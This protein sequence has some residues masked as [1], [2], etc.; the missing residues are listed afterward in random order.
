MVL[1]AAKRSRVAAESDSIVH[2]MTKI[3][4]KK[5][6]PVTTG[7]FKSPLKLS[8]HV[9]ALIDLCNDCICVCACG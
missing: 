4:K 1:V 9:Q 6:L 7:P 2:R 8:E 3:E 5:V